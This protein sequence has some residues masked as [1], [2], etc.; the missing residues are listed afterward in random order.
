[1]ITMKLAFS[2]NLL[3]SGEEAFLKNHEQ[4]D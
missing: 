1:M 2:G 3:F 4:H